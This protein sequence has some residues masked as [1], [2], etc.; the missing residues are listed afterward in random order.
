MSSAFIF[1]TNQGK[2]YTA[3][4]N[5]IFPS[6]VTINSVVSGSTG[7]GL[8][9]GVVA[10]DVSNGTAVTNGITYNVYSFQP[11]TGRLPASSTSS[12]A[13]YT[14]NYSCLN[15]TTIYVLAVGGGGGGTAWGGAGGG[16]GGVVMNP[17]Y[18]PAGSSSITISVGAGGMA[19]A[20]TTSTNLSNPSNGSNTTVNFTA[21]SSANILA[22]G[23]G[24][25]GSG[26]VASSSGGSGGGG[27]NGSPTSGASITNNN[28]YGNSGG[29]SVSG[30]CGGG[31]GAGTIGKAGVNA[32]IINGGAGGNG[33]QCFLPGISKFSPSGIVYSNYYWGGGG[34]GSCSTSN[35]QYGNGGL[36]GGGG[37][38]SATTSVSGGEM[39]TN[40]L[41]NGSNG[42]NSST[43]STGGAGGTN[44]GGGG[45][46]VWWGSGG[47]GGSGIVVIAFPSAAVTYNQAAVLPASIYNSN[48]YSATLNNAS[49]SSFA[50]NSIKGAY[51]CRLLNYNYF[52]PIITLRYNTDTSGSFTQNFYSDI[53]GNMGTGYLG[54]GQSASSWLNANGANTTY[55]FVTKWYSQGM[56]TSFNCATQNTTTLQPIY[57]VSYGLINFAYT[58]SA[59]GIVAPQAG[60]LNLPNGSFPV[61]DS[62]FTIVSKIGNFNTSYQGQLFFAGGSSGTGGFIYGIMGNSPSTQYVQLNING[63]TTLYTPNGTAA[64]NSVCTVKYNSFTTAGSVS[65][66]INANLL[67]YVNGAQQYIGSISSATNFLNSNYT[68]GNGPNT[69]YANSSYT[70]QLQMYDIYIFKAT[71]TGPGAG[72]DQGIIEATQSVYTPLPLM[73]VTLTNIT[74]TNFTA[75]WTFSAST[76][77]MYING[78]VYGTVISGQ[79]IT[80]GVPPGW[81]IT[82]YAY[83]STYNLLASGKTSCYRYFKFQVLAVVSDTYVGI[84]QIIIGY[85]NVMINY[86]G[87]TATDI[88]NNGYSA[89]VP[90][91]ALN[92]TTTKWTVAYLSGFPSSLIVDFKTPRQVNSYTYVTGYDTSG[93]DPKTFIFYGSN[94]NVNWIILGSQTNITN[95][96]SR[97][98]QMPWYS[99]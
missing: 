27:G 95:S 23:G 74:T 18:L 75:S 48:L 1:R 30:F 46:A 89:E 53:C 47:A 70:P 65:T 90:S 51:A 69:L 6:P 66:G 60:Y 17:V 87:A 19:G 5:Y 8:I 13:T 54:T 26:A 67:G 85:N 43:L 71:L 31:G 91:N 68:I 32:T 58:G 64:L 37:G 86:T 14:I 4:T 21:N 97:S 55:A 28:N 63:I 99:C 20:S 33:I 62:S 50:Y 9:A 88:N 12:Q 83:N 81:N 72:T 11:G 42:V 44:T 93:R 36:G 39:G 96:G 41:N 15:A 76:Y 29:T 61:N 25:G 98:Y 52:G 80:P 22:W 2:S 34:G 59:G 57:D 56:D 7:T 45:G 82:V 49:L 77:V 35:V 84:Q 10:S 73:T 24:S 94:D 40:G 92:N 38:S 16:A 3:H 79:T 78:S